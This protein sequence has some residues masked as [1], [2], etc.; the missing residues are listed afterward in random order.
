MDSKKILSADILDILFEGRNKEYG[1]YD[2]RRTY[3]RRLT[4]ALAVMAGLCVL[5]LLVSM[6]QPESI[7]KGPTLIQ[8]VQLASVEDKK[9]E[10][11]PVIPP[12]KTDPP[13]VEMAQF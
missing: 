3:R 9:K 7:R 10:E 6:I 1:A 4:T 5:I 2:L 12:P 13:R 8:D 11:P